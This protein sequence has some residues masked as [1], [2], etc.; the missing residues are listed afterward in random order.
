MEH[1]ITVSEQVYEALKRQARRSRK[2]LD[3]LVESWLKQH[4]DLESYP[5]LEWRQGPGGWRVGIIGTA[6]DVYAVAG[7][8][9]AGHSPQEIAD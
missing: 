2:P 8:S 9:N 4:L 1:R 3:A 6:I 5:E 7:Y